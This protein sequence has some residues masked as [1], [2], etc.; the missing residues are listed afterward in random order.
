MHIY[1]HCS[2]IH[3]WQEN[4]YI[5]LHSDLRQYSATTT[6]GLL[7]SISEFK[8]KIKTRKNQHTVKPPASPY[9]SGTEFGTS[10]SHLDF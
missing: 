7:I 4:L 1:G 6:S 9:S 3:N 10:Y 2:I 5:H 8:N